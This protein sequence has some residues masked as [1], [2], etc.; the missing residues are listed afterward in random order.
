VLVEPFSPEY[1]RLVS[2]AQARLTP[3]E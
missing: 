1:A 2:E 3:T